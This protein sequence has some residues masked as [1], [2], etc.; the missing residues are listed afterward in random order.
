MKH[1]LTAE[2]ILRQISSKDI[3]LGELRNIAKEIKKDHQLAN[4]LWS[5][6][7]FFARQ[8]AILIM[9]KKLLT[10]DVIDSL[11]SDIS[12][13]QDKEK[14]Q[15]IDWLIANQLTKDKKTLALTE[16]WKDSQSSLKR[17]VYWYYQGRQRWMGQTPPTSNGELLSEIEKHIEKEVPEVQWTMNFSADW[18]GVYDKKYR[19]RCMALG[20]KIGLYKGKMYQ[21][22]VHRNIY[23]SS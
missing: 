5:S 10:E 20:E 6:T 14:L 11:V 21:K 7:Y 17:R 19:E 12:Q 16:R 1:P 4:E 3:K 15:L 18:I 9:D 2:N 13:Y 8:L 23:L 22:D